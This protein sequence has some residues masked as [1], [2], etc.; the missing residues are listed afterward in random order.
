MIDKFLKNYRSRAAALK[1]DGLSL[2]FKNKSGYVLIIVLLVISMLFSISAEFLITA[3][4]NINYI[5]KIDE[6][7]KGLLIAR[8]GINLATLVLKADENSK[9]QMLLP[10][11]CGQNVDCFDDIWALVNSLP[12]FPIADGALRLSIE[13]ENSKINLN[14]ITNAYGT[15]TQYYNMTVNFLL[16]LGLP[17]DIADAIRDWVDPDDSRSPYGA[18]SSDYYLSLT[19]PYRAKNN[20]M[21]SI[22]ELLLV[23]GMT[24]ELFYGLGGGNAGMENNLIDNN[25]KNTGAASDFFS[26]LDSENPLG[27]LSDVLSNESKS[28]INT[29]MEKSRSLSDYFRVYGESV[30]R[31]NTD[32]TLQEGSGSG[33]AGKVYGN[34][35]KININTAPYRILQTLPL[36]FT[37]SDSMMT[38]DII[39]QIINGR[40]YKNMNDLKTLIKDDDVRN[41]LLD[42]KSY[43]FKITS[44]GIINNTTVKIICYLKRG[45]SGTVL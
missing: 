6:R 7:L 43:I 9:L 30:Q 22:D 45:G 13:D 31:M 8:A 34:L 29:G 27:S 28:E 14:A 42:V 11:S 2:Y 39:I 19:N 18:E 5:R 23:K 36:S 24:P 25:R 26:G 37:S 32:D 10:T 33:T 35:D 3:Q 15:T 20:E 16:N 44:Y 1:R 41:K 40:P 12:E 17:I 21:D 4:T 38:E